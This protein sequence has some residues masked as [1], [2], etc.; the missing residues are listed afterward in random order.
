VYS[1]P[2]YIRVVGPLCM[3]YEYRLRSRHRFVAPDTWS[4]QQL[5]PALSDQIVSD[6]YSLGL[7]RHLVTIGHDGGFTDRYGVYEAIRYAIGIHIVRSWPVGQRSESFML[8]VAY[9][10]APLW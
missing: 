10:C 1:G 2:D 9:P 5:Y 6:M 4:I 8:T 3:H 7:Q